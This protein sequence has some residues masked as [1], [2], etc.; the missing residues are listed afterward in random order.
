[1]EYAKLNV[2][3]PSRGG[4]M[5]PA[6]RTLAVAAGTVIAAEYLEAVEDAAVEREDEW[7]VAT[8]DAADPTKKAYMSYEP[9]MVAE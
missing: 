2:K 5:N 3:V 9:L 6:Y 7:Y 4:R 1:M 8:N